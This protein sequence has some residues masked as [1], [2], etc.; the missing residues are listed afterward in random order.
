[1]KSGMKEIINL[2]VDDFCYWSEELVITRN[3]EF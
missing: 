2:Y 3:T 1:M